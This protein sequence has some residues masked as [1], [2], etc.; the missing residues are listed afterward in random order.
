M[1]RRTAIA[2]AGAAVAVLAGCDLP[3]SGAGPTDSPGSTTASA[4]PDADAA[5][6]TATADLLDAAAALLTATVAAH[7][8]LADRLAPLGSAHAAHLAL[9]DDVR[10]ERS[11]P[12]ASGTT[13][14]PVPARP[15]KALARV[16]ARETAL[17]DHLREAATQAASGRYARVLAVVAASVE[18]H[19]ASLTTGS[20]P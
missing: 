8:G 19:L 13:T 1:A 3:G 11:E 20:A 18:Q 15:A 6:A 14:P 2:G 9:F 5:S 7:P 4:A 16:R 12:E 17:A 10:P